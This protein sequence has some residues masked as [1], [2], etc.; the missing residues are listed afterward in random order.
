[1]AREGKQS[2][3]GEALIGSSGVR[4]ETEE[5]V[6]DR[7]LDI[8]GGTGKKG[9]RGTSFFD[10]SIPNLLTKNFPLNDS[11]SSPKYGVGGVF[12]ENSEKSVELL[13]DRSNEPDL[14]LS[15]DFLSNDEKLELE[16]EGE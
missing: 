14:F 10:C 13:N 6:L 12:G 2:S 8:D 11:V 3:L 16:G 5:E 7:V 15:N 9:G 4:D 1:M